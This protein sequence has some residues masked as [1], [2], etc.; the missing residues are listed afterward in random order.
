[1][2][3]QFTKI[4]PA[5]HDLLKRDKDQLFIKEPKN[6]IAIKVG[7]SLCGVSSKAW[8]HFLLQYLPKLYLIP[9]IIKT[10]NQS[11]TIILPNYTDPQVRE[12]VF[13]YL[14]KLDGIKILELKNDEVVQCDTLYHIDNT[15]WLSESIEYTSPIDGIIPKFVADSLKK[16]LLVDYCV[17]DIKNNSSQ[18]ALDYKLFIARNNYRNLLNYAE[19]EDLFKQKGYLIVNPHKVSLSEKIRL[20]RN[21]SLIVGPHSSGFSNVL[22]CKKGTKVLMMN[23]FQKLFEPWLGFYEVH[24]DINITNISGFDEYSTYYNSSYTIPLAKIVSACDELGF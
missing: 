18:N 11:I 20:F 8:A 2:A 16:N 1:M 6:V 13:D 9:D 22:F 12:I 14:N 4:M 19:V 21:A 5:D 10:T 24:F 17:T 23:N 3:P 15:A 7:F